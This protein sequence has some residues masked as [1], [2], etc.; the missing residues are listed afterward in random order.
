[1]L[2]AVVVS[3]LFIN[4]NLLTVYYRTSDVGD[5]K[6]YTAQA[7]EQIDKIHQYDSGEY[8]ISQTTTR[9]MGSNGTTAYYNGSMAYNYKSI[10]EYT[11]APDGRQ[12]DFLTRLGY[13]C[14]GINMQIVN[15][16]VIG[17]D[18]LLG[19]K[20]IL[21]PYAI[22]GLE[23]VEELENYNG[24][25]VYENPYSLPLAFV[26]DSKESEAKTEDVNPFE[27]QNELFSELSGEPIKIYRRLNFERR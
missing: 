24:K 5:F 14:E 22:N 18:S 8:R 9:A 15:T 20:Y 26:Y 10:T 19:V 11:S 23:P 16:S 3:E 1:M 21:S 12:M 27:Y 2:A 13:R 17:A 7:I 25:T 6:E 4:L